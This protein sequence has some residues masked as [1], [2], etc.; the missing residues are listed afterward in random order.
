[1]KIIYT[2]IQYKKEGSTVHMDNFV[3]AFRAIGNDIIDN[4]IIGFYVKDSLDRS[5]LS[6]ITIKI[7]SVILRFVYLWKTAQLVVLNK[8]DVLIFRH[9]GNMQL[10]LTIFFLSLFYPTILEINA[11]S[12]IEN[13]NGASRVKNLFE[14]LTIWSVSHCFA[15]SSIVKEHV[16]NYLGVKEDKVS[17]IENG[18]DTEKFSMDKYDSIEKKNLHL[19]DYF[20]IGFV[21]T[22]KPWHGF[23]YLI[24]L[25]HAL[26]SDYF[27]IKLLAVG[28]SRERQMYEKKIIEKGLAD[29]F[30]FTGHIQHVDIPKY[31]SVMDITIAPHDR[32]SFKSIGGFHGSP[33]KIFE[34]MAMEKPVI[35]TPIGQIKDIIEDD[36]SGCLIFSDQIDEVKRAVIKLY[37]DKNYRDSLGKNARNVVMTNYT[38]EINARK[39]ESICKELVK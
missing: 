30:I 22:F 39:I 38:W 26:K 2:S 17:V 9:A 4:R 23:D 7:Y 11:V 15:V 19:D 28:D 36:I 12:S 10:F 6:K 21:G 3:K 29:S 13:R 24:E 14:R 20:I 34:Y 8:P 18:V 32:N 35:A 1:M 16:V 33:L 25:M 5:L 31:I 37:E 27:D